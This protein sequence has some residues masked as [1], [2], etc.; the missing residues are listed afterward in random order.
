[1]IKSGD[2]IVLEHSPDVFPWITQE[3]PISKDLKLFLAAHTH[4]GQVWF[5][6]LG[7]LVVPSSYGQKYAYGHIKENDV[8]MFVTTGIGTSI[9]PIRFLVPP[10][11]AVLTIES[12]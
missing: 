11:I 4:G 1:M 9:L 10:E 2:L 8:D 6:V 3:Y 12:E 7:S 5:P